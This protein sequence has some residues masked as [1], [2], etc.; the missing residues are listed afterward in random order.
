MNKLGFAIN[1]SSNGAQKA[2]EC[3]SGEWSRYVGDIREYIKLFEGLSGSSDVL[4]FM[5][6]V[7]D[8]CLIS[9][10]MNISGRGIDFE[11][12]WIFIPN[13]IRISGLEVCNVIS[14]AKDKLA[15]ANLR[16]H[17]D[18][19]NG[20][21]SKEYPEKGFSSAYRPSSQ[22]GYAYRIIGYYSLAELL[23]DGCRY[24]EYYSNF[25]K[26][27]LLEEGSDVKI[28][29]AYSNQFKDISKK[30]L[31]QYCVVKTPS[32][33][34]V[35]R[36][37]GKD[38]VLVSENGT[39]LPA[40]FSCKKDDAVNIYAKK[41]SFEQQ[42]LLRCTVK[43]CEDTFT[44]P[45]GIKQKWQ[46]RLKV[47]R[48]K[49]LSEHGTQLSNAQIKINGTPLY[50]QGILIDEADCNN[51][52][53]EVS[54]SGYE[55]VSQKIN[56]FSY[57]DLI[58]IRLPKAIVERLSQI[59]LK[60]DYDGEIIIKSKFFDFDDEC[61]LK[62]YT[63]DNN[64]IIRLSDWFIWKQR[65]IGFLGGT[66]IVFL[67]FFIF[68]LDLFFPETHTE[69]KDP[70]IVEENITEDQEVIEDSGI[71]DYEDNIDSL[72][73]VYLDSCEVWNRNEMEKYPLLQG[74]F[75]DLNTF[76]VDK[77]TEKWRQVL[78]RSTNFALILN[79][80]DKVKKKMGD[81]FESSKFNKPEISTY[82]REDD[83]DI[84]IKNYRN[85]IEETAKKSKR[86][87]PVNPY[88]DGRSQIRKDRGTGNSGI[89]PK[90][91]SKTKEVPIANNKSQR[92]S[93]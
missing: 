32:K 17:I 7:K 83:F 1:Y 46:Y 49:V 79:S 61:P 80:Y 39:P 31:V 42:L 55:T 86:T 85:Y 12:G 57:S 58:Y 70:D 82:N 65:I 6:F 40:Y 44:I 54:A 34:E 35:T 75:D 9:L 43:E 72:A 30:E 19:I 3:N 5:S 76:N 68:Y 90:E 87:E 56:L 63:Y 73:I 37:L 2:H 22:Q 8:G 69:G 59:K 27:F 66:T 29:N 88:V 47:S 93:I 53:V 10:L 62:G 20:F 25:N 74:L 71:S 24:Q 77:L 23:E 13:S 64:N 45:A 89:K 81:D 36:A 60:H 14:F 92:G 91:V 67:I 11:C 52:N 15:D 50:S 4:T 16:E 78:S 84:N 51:V 28:N 38:V 18:E 33:D 26:V 48:F 21:F 41:S